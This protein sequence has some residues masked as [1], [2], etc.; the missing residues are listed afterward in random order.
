[1]ITG[2]P[3][4]CCHAHPSSIVRGARCATGRAAEP[5]GVELP[6]ESAGGFALLS[7]RRLS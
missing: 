7:H 3:V 6:D 2:Q 1:M 5:S 4:L